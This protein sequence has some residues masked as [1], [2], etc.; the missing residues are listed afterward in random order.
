MAQV[1]A[2]PTVAAE[3]DEVGIRM[4][5]SLRAWLPQTAQQKIEATNA[6]AQV[7]P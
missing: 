2:E 3:Q 1:Q 7:N 5:D 4:P 6:R